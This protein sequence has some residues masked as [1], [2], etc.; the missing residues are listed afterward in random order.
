[1]EQFTEEQK[2][3]LLAMASICVVSI[4]HSFHIHREEA[5]KRKFYRKHSEILKKVTESEL[6]KKAS[7]AQRTAI[8]NE[9]ED[10]GHLFG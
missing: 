4:V 2:L 1:M 7:F 9:F 10:A 8:L 5:M 3:A 6:Y